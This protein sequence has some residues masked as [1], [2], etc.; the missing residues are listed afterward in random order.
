MTT[1]VVLPGL[2]GTARLHSAFVDAVRTA[3]DDVMVMS[4]PPDESLGYLALEARIRP[5]LPASVPFVL[6]G[7]SFSGPIAISIAANPLANMHGLILSTTFAASPNALFAPFAPLTRIA[8]VRVLP[9]AVLRWWLFGRWSTAALE[10]SLANA[11]LSVAPRVLR[12]RAA[13]ALRINV[14]QACSAVAMPVLYLRATHDRLLSPRACRQVMAAIPHC[15]VK[16]IA[17]PHL[18]LQTQPAACAR[19]VRDFAKHLAR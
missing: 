19:A 4:Y 16:D 11:L 12:E 13:A 2:D 10:Q 18:L 5:A 9:R 15:I 8:P 1:L 6:M 3:F 7:E 14:M 17:G